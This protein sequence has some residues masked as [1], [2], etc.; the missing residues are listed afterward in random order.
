[1]GTASG[2]GISLLSER[3]DCDRRDVLSADGLYLNPVTIW[4]ELY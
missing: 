3:G 4:A 2:P 1:M